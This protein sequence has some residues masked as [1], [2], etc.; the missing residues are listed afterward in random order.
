MRDPV[1]RDSSMDFDSHYPTLH[2][3][4]MAQLI[5]NHRFMDSPAWFIILILQW[6]LDDLQVWLVA[7]SKYALP[8]G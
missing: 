3:P 1:G 4:C 7:A 5:H 8:R 2:A 6:P